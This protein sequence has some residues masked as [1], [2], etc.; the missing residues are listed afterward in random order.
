[1]KEKIKKLL[2]EYASNSRITSKELGKRINSSQQSAFYLLNTHKEKDLILGES[3]IIDAIK[4]GYMNTLIG[5][6]FKKLNDK[7]KADTI[8]ELKKINE[9]VSI[10]ESKEGFDLLV[11]ISTKN[12]AALDKI[13][14]EIIDQQER[15]INT[16]FIFPIITKYIY[17]RKYLKR[18]KVIKSKNL[19]ADRVRKE[20][21]ESEKKV[22]NELIKEP[23]KKLIDIAETTNIS[24]KSVSKAIK[25]LEQKYIIKGYDA[26]LNH[27]KLGI[28]REIIFLKFPSEGFKEI[29]KC[30]DYAKDNKN[31][32]EAIKVIGSTQLI[33][34]IESLDE[35]DIIR[36]LR[37]IFS[38]QDYMIF[39]SSRIHKKNYFPQEILD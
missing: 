33:I 18:P 39:K 28:N 35:I 6:N 16:F 25:S 30:L 21:N 8:E 38:I 7:I 11:E 24:T 26:I 4:L 13:H 9:I 2:F 5:L 37:S 23:S 1:M 31:I 12:L 27:S 19:F 20:L 32:I 36:E 14:S 10:E 3:T 17:P 22:L 34:I 29:S 15:K